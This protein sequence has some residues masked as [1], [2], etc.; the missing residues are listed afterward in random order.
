[1]PSLRQP[2]QSVRARGGFT[3]QLVVW[4]GIQLLGSGLAA[5]RVPL[6]ANAPRAIELLA[7]EYLLVAQIS[8][9]SLIF[10]W[11]MRSS[12]SS[13]VAM[14]TAWPMIFFAGLLSPVP[15]YTLILIGAYVSG[16]LLALA[17]LRPPLSSTGVPVTTPIA[18]LWACGGP[19]LQFLNLEYGGTPLQDSLLQRIALGPIV[20][21][22]GLIHGEIQGSLEVL[23]VAIVTAITLAMWNRLLRSR[24]AADKLGRV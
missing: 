16:W 13:V 8:V 11:L 22:I 6:W 9:S 7:L 14:A 2:S 18:A 23:A 10:P 15:V 12:A 3:A 19:I 20:A 17:I 4:L 1:M 24:Q 5:A 21:G